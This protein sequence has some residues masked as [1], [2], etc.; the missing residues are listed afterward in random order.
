MEKKPNKSD[1][2][3]KLTI[4]RD[5]VKNDPK[6]PLFKYIILALVF[7]V[8]GAVLSHYF[9]DGMVVEKVN[10]ITPDVIKQSTTDYV[11]Q[12]ESS[13]KLQTLDTQ[14][15]VAQNNQETI[16]NAS[17]YIT[18]RRMATVSSQ[19][20]GLLIRVNVEEGMDVAQGQ[21]L[22]QLD[23]TTAMIGLEQA[24]SQLFSTQTQLYRAQAL[25]NEARRQYQRTLSNAYSSE[26]DKSMSLTNQE[27]ALADV[28]VIK[29]NIAVAK[30]EVK[31]RQELLDQHTIRAPF[32]GVVTMKNAQPGEIVAPSSAGG[33]F[34]RT[35]ICTL[36]DMQSLEIEVDVNESFIGRVKSGQKVVAQLD[37]YPDWQIP[38]SVI[39]II[40]TADRG[41]ATV[42][43]RIKIEIQSPKILP[44]MGVKVAF[45]K[46]E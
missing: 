9:F 45:Y 17:G 3:N 43:V 38:A 5:E 28:K 15:N 41:K 35:G 46:S 1:L 26:A 42:T 12:A 13:E 11:Q 25:L 36:V 6:M 4:N 29:A 19:I 34:T 21:I 24:Q 27:T 37:A 40:P 44:D 16:L 32:A 22:A 23:N 14:K 8:L 7:T 2:L 18:A 33:G 39:A 10:Q 31:R 30:I 20:M